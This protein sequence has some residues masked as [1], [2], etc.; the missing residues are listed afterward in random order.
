MIKKIILIS[1]IIVLIILF[2][3]WPLGVIS[4]LTEWLAMF[5]NVIAKC[6]K[7]LASGLDWFGWNGLI[8]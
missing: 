3:T 6:L 1:L 7:W 2:G 8:G 4:K 5:I